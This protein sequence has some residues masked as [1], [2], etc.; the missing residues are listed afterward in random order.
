M[1]LQSLADFSILLP[2]CQDI[3]LGQDSQNHPMA[4]QGHLPLAAWP[5]SRESLS[6]SGLSEGVVD[7]LKRSLRAS[8]ESEYSSA[9]RKWE[10]RCLSRGADPLSAPLKD[11][12]EFLLLE[13]QAGKQYQT[14]NTTRSTI[15]M[16]H[17][18]VDGVRIGQHPLVSRM[19]KGT[20]NGRPPA[21][22]STSTW[23]VDMVISYYESS[24]VNSQLSLQTLTH[25][26]A[27]LFALANADRCSDLAALDLNHRTYQGNGV[28]FIIPGL[29]KSRRKG[30][31]IEAFYPSFP[32]SPKLCPVQALKEYEKRS[33]KLRQSQETL[34]SYP[35][36][37][38]TPQ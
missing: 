21:P 16:T 9:W 20:F 4:V 11:V 37:S 38:L 7:L 1:L 24:P 26:V 10:C 22:R 6:T 35:S 15:S 18:E 25:K 29:T 23:D 27:M 17:M 36:G 32:E 5:I 19:M 12:L 13:F 33:E 34:C 30:P 8:T 28:K 3:V 31:P 2:P 14:I